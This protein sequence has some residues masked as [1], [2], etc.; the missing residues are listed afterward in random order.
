M[1][2]D[3][4]LILKILRWIL[5]ILECIPPEM[6]HQPISTTARELLDALL[7]LPKKGED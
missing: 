4:M 3:I 2:I 1:A 7:T 5:H 6:D